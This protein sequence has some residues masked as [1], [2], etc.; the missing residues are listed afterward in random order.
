MMT[1]LQTLREAP[2][3]R[4]GWASD[5]ACSESSGEQTIRRLMWR[6]HPQITSCQNYTSYFN[7]QKHHNC[8]IYYIIMYHSYLITQEMGW[9]FPRQQGWW[10]G[11]RKPRSVGTSQ[12][13]EGRVGWRPSEQCLL[14]P[15]AGCSPRGPRGCGQVRH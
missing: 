14:T 7:T 4:E 12:P 5:I 9:V 6:P 15:P 3:V 11:P 8:S 1:S 2:G 10:A 13:R